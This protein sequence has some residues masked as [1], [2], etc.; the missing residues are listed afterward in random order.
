MIKFDDLKSCMNCIYNRVDID[1]RSRKFSY[2]ALNKEEHNKY[3]I[4]N[5]FFYKLEG[6]NNML[7]VKISRGNEK[8]GSIKSISLP[9]VVTCR[10]GAPCVKS[11][12]ARRLQRFPNV[13][14]AYEN[15]LELYLSDACRYFDQVTAAAEKE[16]FFRW[17][18]SGDIVNLDYFRFMCGTAKVCENTKFLCFTKK[19]EIVNDFIKEGG[20]IPENLIIIFSVWNNL[21]LVNPY[22]LPAAHVVPKETRGLW[23]GNE[24]TGNCLECAINN[25]RCWSFSPGGADSVFL[26]EH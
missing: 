24:C 22:N 18:V 8:M 9:P 17:H 23:G 4:C 26:V 2:C 13:R 11:C 7:N 3:T 12:Y 10:P 14:K 15:N 19:Y 21:E 25:K 20:I 6:V 16:S 1:A 5:Q